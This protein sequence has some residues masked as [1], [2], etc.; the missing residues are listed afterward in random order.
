[1]QYSLGDSAGQF[2]EG[3]MKSTKISISFVVFQENLSRQHSMKFRSVSELFV[4]FQGPLWI[5]L[6]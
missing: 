1:M 4:Q 5:T 6:A 2:T 3:I